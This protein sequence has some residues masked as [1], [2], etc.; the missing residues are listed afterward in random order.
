[1]R[2]SRDFRTALVLVTVLCL[3]ASGAAVAQQQT[4]DL[5]GKVVDEKGG[6][7]PGVT[8]TLTGAGGVK[9]AESDA[10]GTF[11][12]IGLYPGQYALKAEL[13]GFSSV[14]QTGIGVRLGG[15]S[16]VELTLSSEVKETI[17]VTAEKP[18]LNTRELNS[19][20][21]LAAKDLEQVPTARD[22]WSLLSQAPGVQVDRVNVGGNESG[23][24][25]NF[26][27]GGATASDNTFSVDGMI[28]T[29]MAAVGGS[30]TYFDFGAYEEV[31]VTTAST[32]VGIQTAGV[33]INQITKRGTNT[34]RGD[35]RY[36]QTEGNWQALPEEANGNKIDGI[37]EYGGNIGGPLV[38]DHLWIWGSYGFNDIG[39]IVGVTGQLDRT[40][41]KDN[42][43][44]LN[45]QW[46][47]NSGTVHYWKNDKL[48]F[49]RGAGFDR[50]PE[51]TWDQTTPSEKWKF[52]DTQLFGSNFLLTALHSHDPGAFTLHPKGGN[53]ADVFLDEN[54]VWQGSFF[55]FDQTGIIDQSKVDGTAFFHTGTWDNELKFGGSYRTQDND[56]ISTLPHGRAVL[57]CQGYG[58]DAGPDGDIAL[59]EWIRHNVA[60]KTK[61]QAAWIQDT[62]TQDRWTFTGGVRYDKQNAHNKAVHDPGSPEAPNGLLPVIDFKGD[63]A[64]G[65]DWKSLVP[66]LGV[67]Y[68]AGQDRRTLL[69]GTYSQ[70]AAQLG[71]W[72]AN[73]VSP[74]A[75][76]SYVYYY[77]TDANHNHKFDPSE[78]GSLSY[79]Y[80]A[81]V[82][83]ADPTKSANRLQKGLDPYK[84]Q[85]ATFSVQ[86]AFANNF[87]VSAN[88]T[89][90]R[91]SDLLEQR[92]LVTDE[93]GTVRP[94]T[95]AD[96]VFRDNLS[97]VLP[98][99]AVATVARYQLRD[100]VSA[101]GGNEL[102]NG[103]RQI[104]YTGINIG[105]QK[106][107]ANRWSMRGN[108]NYGNNKLKI[109]S[110][111]KNQD[112]PTNRI[113]LGTGFYGDTSDIFVETSYGS[114]SL[115]LLNSRWSFN[116][117]GLYQIAP[118]K[119]WGFN[120]AAN[121]SGREGYPFV[122]STTRNVRGLQL[123]SR[124]DAFRFSNVYTVDARLEKDVKIGDM[125]LTFSI[126]GFNLLNASPVLQRNPL[127]PSDAA[128]LS[129]SYPVVERLSPR[130]F[131]WGVALHFR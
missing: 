54:G 23:Q 43:A 59:V 125:G 115:V 56:S 30:A 35:A 94:A 106:P 2:L 4:G 22:P 66:R 46:G 100:G 96:Y 12:F 97:R 53:N 9:L 27:V 131:R 34:W 85:E 57:S 21:S 52:E 36:L 83:L 13:S 37:K 117:N 126:D 74:T 77:F 48:K 60:V 112:D 86:H 28:L 82:N 103:D 31:Q 25:S 104:D 113:T 32:D 80:V 7:L 49:G 10:D 122:P 76:Y 108:V 1:M 93:T 26:L 128:D 107:L 99:G 101:T 70:Y 62:L 64:N 116:V 118:D 123:T 19:G 124:L 78:S 58:C 6:L 73:Y 29:D 44:K 68:A 75:P 119:P 72:V 40:K 105:F 38:Q 92:P 120:V 41:I 33:T 45:F 16:Q 127:A 14:E 89:F 61:Y 51:T 71:Q 47:S 5:Y 39:N 79:Y 18:L 11:R 121:I 130:V 109:G 81:N 3:A 90:R 91:T 55:I 95:S 24:Q 8:L 129:T 63:N 67:T 15:K 88:L 50:S 102:A 84:T 110:G 111:F 42:N 87:N 20:V 69:R 98:N 65:L 17:V 114:H